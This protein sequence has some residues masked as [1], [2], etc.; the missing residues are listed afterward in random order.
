MNTK[1]TLLPVD[2]TA[3]AHDHQDTVE[4]IDENGNPVT[5]TIIANLELDDQAYAI[6]TSEE[7]DPDSEDELEVIVFRVTEED[8][9]FVF[10]TIEDENELNEVVEAYNQLLEDMEKEEN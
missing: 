9:E 4:L 5:F 1:D 6:L 8:E 3:H 2:D 10:E 7:E